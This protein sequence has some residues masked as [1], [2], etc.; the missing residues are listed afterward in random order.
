MKEPLFLDDIPEDQIPQ[1]KRKSQGEVEEFMEAIQ[2]KP[3]RWAVFS[4][5]NSPAAAS[6]RKKQ[7][8]EAKRYVNY[9]IEWG[10]R[11]MPTND[12]DAETALIVRWIES[13]AVELLDPPPAGTVVLDFDG[14]PWVLFDIDGELT[15]AG[16]DAQNGKPKPRKILHFESAEELRNFTIVHR[17]S[18]LGW[19]HKV[20]DPSS[21]AHV[22]KAEEN[23]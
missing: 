3:M 22:S 11:R 4:K 17:P 18:A 6:G 7:V 19:S 21:R 10:T 15:W 13:K 8:Q 23:P 1:A 16:M 9:P 14:T 12:N 20:D 2:A 5:H